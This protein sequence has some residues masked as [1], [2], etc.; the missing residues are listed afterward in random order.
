MKLISL[1]ISALALIASGCGYVDDNPR[2][3]RVV[4]QAYLDAYAQHNPSKI[5]RVLAPE[6]VIAV[7]AGRTCEEG[8][9]PQLLQ[10]HPRLRAGRTR[11]APSPPGNPRLFVAV[12]GQP[13]REIELGR[14]GSIWRV[15]NGGTVAGR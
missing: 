11:K 10:D 1:F 4:A 6:V 14:Y 9:A 8:L 7:A 13:G 5:C 2:A 12:Q 3:A 15:I